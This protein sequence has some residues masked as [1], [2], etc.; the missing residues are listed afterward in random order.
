MAIE[1]G[2]GSLFKQVWLILFIRY[3]E[4]EVNRPLIKSAKDTELGALWPV[5]AVWRCKGIWNYKKGKKEKSLLPGHLK[6]KDNRVE[7]GIWRGET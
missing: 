3:M 6:V 1:V 4:E 5:T 2:Q 7:H